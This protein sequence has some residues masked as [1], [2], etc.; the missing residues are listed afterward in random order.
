MQG[1]HAM[2]VLHRQRPSKLHIQL[3]LFRHELE[4]PSKVQDAGTLSVHGLD[5]LMVAVPT[6]SFVVKLPPPP[7]GHHACTPP[8]PKLQGPLT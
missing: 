4:G 2:R 8:S 6:T 7:C 5:L 3:K 1:R